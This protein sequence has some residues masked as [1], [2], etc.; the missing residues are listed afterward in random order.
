MSNTFNAFGSSFPDGSSYSSMTALQAALKEFY[1]PEKIR[2]ITYQKNPFFAMLSKN[3]DASGQVFIQPLIYG[4]PQG[5]SH[6]FATAQSNQTASRVTRFVLTWAQD[7]GLVTVTGLTAMA[8]RDNAGAFFDAMKNE[9]DGIF[10]S[11]KNRIGGDLF[12]SGTGTIGSSTAALSTGVITLADPRSV[13]QFEYGMVLE[14]ANTDGGAAIGSPNYGYVVARDVK[15]GT[16]T[17]STASNGGAASPTAWTGTLYYRK[18][19]DRN[20]ALTGLAGW[21]PTSVASNDS[22]FGVNRSED[23]RLYGLPYDGSGQPV[24]EALI[25]AVSQLAQEGSDPE[26]LVT[27]FGTWAAL[28]KSV[29]SKKQYLDFTPEIGVK[30][31]GLV[32]NTPDGEIAVFA[33]RSC[34]G[35]A[36]Y[37]LDMSTWMLH[38]MKGVPHIQTELDGLTHLRASA[39]DASE[40]RIAYYGQLGCS[41][42]GLNGQVTFQS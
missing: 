41:A 14:A 34:Q 33:D 12:R 35:R 29:G 8:T 3:E 40:T 30:F 18:A 42:P 31:K 13:T 39:A 10:R 19:G 23:N 38:S 5:T 1:T 15:N 28:E 4:N 6:T 7:Y 16:I 36:G 24:E 11:L 9:A 22:F 32:V 26:V 20:L 37:I 21:L 17:V 27:N 25:D 2:N